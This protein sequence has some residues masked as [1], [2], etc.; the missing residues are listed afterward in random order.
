MQIAIV[1]DLIY[2]MRKLHRAPIFTLTAVLTLALGVAVVTAMFNLVNGLLLRP[3]PYNAPEQLVVLKTTQPP[4]ADDEADL[5][6][7]EYSE[8]IQHNR[9]FKDIGIVETGNY[10][11]GNG[12]SAFWV[13]GARASASLFRVL[14]GK[15]ILGRAYL[16]EEDLPKGPQVVLLSEGLWRRSFG[17][18]PTI[19]N[20]RIMVD[21]VLRTVVGVIP[22]SAQ[23]PE[24]AEASLFLPVQLQQDASKFD[25]R[26]KRTFFSVARLKPGFTAEQATA[27]LHSVD[28]ELRRLYPDTEAEVT[29]KV[30]PLREYRSRDL[31]GMVLRLFLLASLVLLVA[32]FN[33]ATLLIQRGVGRQHEMAL[34]M[35]LGAA[36]SRILRLLLIENFI[37]SL[38][39]TMTGVLIGYWLF[40]FVINS[41]P[42]GLIEDS[43]VG[44]FFDLR[45]IVFLV[46]TALITTLIFGLVPSLILSRRGM[47][48]QLRTGTNRS[49]AGKGQRLL[50]SALI[51]GEVALTIVAL[52]AA[53]LMVRSF[54]ELLQL[55]PGYT[56]QNV[57]TIKI[58]PPE[59]LYPERTQR[60]AFYTRLLD[61]VKNLPG[62]RAAGAGRERP[63]ASWSQSS[64]T[65]ENQSP[66]EARKN[67]PVY[68]QLVSG[69]Y[70]NACAQKLQRGRLF[71]SGDS[72][73][74]PKVAIIN[75]TLHKRLWPDQDPIG[76]HL[77]V[78]R[79]VTGHQNWLTV[80][81]VVGDTVHTSLRDKPSADVYLPYEQSGYQSLE[82]LVRTTTRPESLIKPIRRELHDID[83][84]IPS[85]DT[86]TMQEVVDEHLWSEKTSLILLTVFGTLA[87]LMAGVGLYGAIADSVSRRTN[88]IGIRV[89]L[90]A[91]PA[92]VL[93]LILAEASLLVGTG[94]AI[95]LTVSFIAGRVLSSFLFKVQVYDVLTY[96]TVSVMT[97]LVAL[98]AIGV[99]AWRSIRIRPTLAL[100][101]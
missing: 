7:T 45:L 52:I 67:P 20:S 19:L 16:P 50:R 98:V 61:R 71:T 25:L 43:L 38:T 40:T 63:L 26:S 13:K 69:D 27:D 9:A 28:T 94:L 53:G 55:D 29:T 86:A 11:V 46:A 1:S 12:G 70:F 62:V 73:E 88:E 24:P 96:A 68:F 8:I 72:F 30:L 97:C 85:D 42:A 18:S 78:S 56:T 49:S 21:G 77:K 81:G 15:P 90:G 44:F 41:I 23:I 35:S 47:F 5:S 91:Q 51:V 32:C 36:P 66:E 54:R 57:L 95:G 3:Y 10:N 92:D 82:L 89:A 22:A 6:F 37:L 80:V 31:Q 75:E 59:S 33:V 100:R 17:A 58:S 93:R 64:L 48:I 74:A 4:H 84:N 87:L 14:A 83:A 2:G 60:I 76:R 65:L 39:G 34:R 101:Q 99:P 79:V